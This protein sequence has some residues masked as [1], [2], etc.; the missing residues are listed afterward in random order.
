MM[1]F[2]NVFLQNKKCPEDSTYKKR[3]LLVSIPGEFANDSK[4]TH[5]D[6]V[7]MYLRL[8][9]TSDDKLDHT[10]NELALEIL[11]KIWDQAASHQKASAGCASH[12]LA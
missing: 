5:K 10:A 2:S 4:I 9:E 11:P 12:L 6:Y 7:E 1:Y 8:V 3:S